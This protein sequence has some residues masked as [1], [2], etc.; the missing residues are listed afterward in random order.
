MM[1]F[2]ALDVINSFISSISAVQVTVYSA[3]TTTLIVLINLT[4]LIYN[5]QK[6]KIKI[7]VS[8]KRDNISIPAIQNPSTEYLYFETANQSAASVNIREIGVI[9]K[10]R[11]C[12]NLVDMPYSFI[13][14]DNQSRVLGSV[15]Y[16]NVPG[17]VASKSI[18]IAQFNFS[19]FKTR[20]E[21]M[22]NSSSAI[23]G[24]LNRMRVVKA[25]EE[26]QKLCDEHAQTIRFK[27]YAI[28]SSGQKF[29]GKEVIITLGNLH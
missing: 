6:D 8:A 29:V 23:P 10:S 2:A 11:R 5:I 3:F 4:N 16:S 21:P 19:D 15:E 25:Y 14:G 28:T 12:L 27:P 18:G 20:Y 22:K 24:Y 13:V 1:I 9:T 7:R 17:F 26:F